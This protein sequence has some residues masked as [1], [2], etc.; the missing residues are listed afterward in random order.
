MKLVTPE[1]IRKLQRALYSRAKREPKFRFYALYDKVY[2]RDILEHAYAL[3]R[4]NKGAAG[5]D[6]MSFEDIERAGAAALTNQLAE[7][8]QDKTYRPG[9]IRR[10]YIP[11]D[12]GAERPLGIPNIRDRVVQMVVKLVL[13]P[14]FEADFESDSY[15]FRPGR[16]A[17]QALEAVRDSIVEGMCWVIDADVSQYFD[18]IPHDKLMKVVANRIVDG[19]MLA[20]LK[21]F[22]N[23]PV[24]DERKGGGPRRPKAGVPQGGVVSPLLA[25]IYLHLLDRSHRRRVERGDLRGRLVRYCDDFVLLTRQPP[26]KELSW[27]RAFMARLGLTLHPDKTCVVNTWQQS[28][29]FLGYRVA[30]DGGGAK[31][32]ISLRS[33]RRIHAHLRQPTRLLFL[34]VGEV[35]DRLNQYIR[36]ARAYFCLAPWWSLRRLDSVIAMR[37]ARW[38]GKKLGLGHPAWSRVSGQE[39]HTEHKL[40][41]WAP[42]PPWDRQL[43]WARE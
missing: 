26:H 12:S 38:W 41:K 13:E 9:P 31:L 16:S 25:N 11:K 37:M 23:A 20:L 4:A 43:A 32:D 30:R 6:G 15:G 3:C 36:G 34:D 40:L 28:F 27:L 39:L 2:R 22:L 10:V 1:K 21:M 17:H 18:T 8:L 14:I 19:S 7:Q 42:K 35:V 33:R 5:P 29:D 24:L